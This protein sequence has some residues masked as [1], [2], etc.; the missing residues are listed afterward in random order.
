MFGSS[1]LGLGDVLIAGVST[2][3]IACR[4]NYRLAPQKRVIVKITLTCY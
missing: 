2:T 3:A 1:E 4:A